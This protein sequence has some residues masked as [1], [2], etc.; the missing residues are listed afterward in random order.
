ME[1]GDHVPR[2]EPRRNTRRKEEAGAHQIRHPKITE[3]GLN[4]GLLRKIEKERSADR[5]LVVAD[6]LGVLAIDLEKRHHIQ[7]EKNQDLEVEDHVLGV[8]VPEVAGQDLRG[9]DQLR[10]EDTPDQRTEDHLHDPKTEGKGH[11]LDLER[12]LD[13]NLLVLRKKALRDP[14]VED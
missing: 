10:E 5:D 13:L 8:G 9:G 14:E 7:E 4:Q 11:G 3:K 12:N 1:V 6:D 2:K